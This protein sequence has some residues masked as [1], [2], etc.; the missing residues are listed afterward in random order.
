MQ[1]LIDTVH[2]MWEWV[3]YYPQTAA[4]V[5]IVAAAGSASAMINVRSW[6][7]GK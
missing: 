4:A 6:R 5:L 3:A 1:A 7:K 2:A